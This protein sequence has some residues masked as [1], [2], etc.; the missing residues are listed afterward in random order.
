MKELG[1]Q[2]AV[3]W[4]LL[5]ALALAQDNF[6]YQRDFS[7]E[8][9]AQRRAKVFEKIG[10]EAV[11]LLQG[12]PA[13]RGFGVFRQNNEFFYLSGI[14]VPQAYLLLDGRTGKTNVYLPSPSRRTSSEQAEDE[15]ALSVKKLTGVDAVHGIESLPE[16]LEKVSVLYTLLGSRRARSAPAREMAGLSRGEAIDILRRDPLGQKRFV[17]LIQ[18]CFGKLTIKNLSPIIDSLR[19]IKSPAEIKLLRRAGKLSALAVIEA[20]RSTEVGVMEY[21]LDAVPKYIYRVS[22]ARG[23]GYPS[24]IAGGANMQYGHYERKDCALN[25]GD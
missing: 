6:Q 2:L 16:H 22:G 4:F 8:E 3:V 15:Y 9:F 5:P 1:K 20:M 18:S 25:D 23:E 12:A 21:Q 24:I 14:E 7:P 13:V 19:A 17:S 11:A 10:A